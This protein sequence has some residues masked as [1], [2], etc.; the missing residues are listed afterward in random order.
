MQP[1]LSSNKLI[2]NLPQVYPVKKNIHKKD[3]LKYT[4][5]TLFNE[6]FDKFN[7]LNQII[8]EDMVNT[9]NDNLIIRDNKEKDELNKFSLIN[10]TQSIDHNTSVNH[11]FGNL[12]TN[13]SKLDAIQINMSSLP[14]INQEFNELSINNRSGSLNKKY[15]LLDNRSK[16][17]LNITEELRSSK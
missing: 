3:H 8:Q 14:N 6:A 13:R 4:S 2:K 16:T 7:S 9:L 17:P 11:Q 5:L 10:D 12:N 15:N 1:T